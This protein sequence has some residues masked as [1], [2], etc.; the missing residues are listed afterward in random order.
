MEGRRVGRHEGGAGAVGSL[1]AQKEALEL[2]VSSL[3]VL[4]PSAEL[5]L[6]HRGR[7][8][9][10]KTNMCCDGPTTVLFSP[11]I[12]LNMNSTDTCSH[13]L[14][15]NRQFIMTSFQLETAT[16]TKR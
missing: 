2:V 16:L 12:T 10:E 13:L 1:S 9:E 14:K 5:C 4:Q 6:F 3:Q 7:Q 15:V 8:P 11:F